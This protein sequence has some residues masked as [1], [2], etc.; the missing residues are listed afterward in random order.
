MALTWCIFWRFVDD[1]EW[2]NKTVR[3]YN[4]VFYVYGSVHR[5]S[6]LTLILLTWSIG[7]ARNN[8]SKWQMGFNS[9]FTGLI[10]VQRD[11]TQNSTFIILQ[12]HSTCFG[13]QP[14]PSS[15]VHK[16]VTTSSGTVQ[17]LPSNVAKLGHV[18]GRQLHK[19]I[20]PVPEA[21]VTVL[22]TPDDWCGW[23]PKHVE[24]TCRIINRLLCVASRWTII[25][26][27]H[28]GSPDSW[29]KKVVLKVQTV[30]YNSHCAKTEWARRPNNNSAGTATNLPG[31]MIRKLRS[32]LITQLETKIN[33]HNCHDMTIDAFIIEG[34]DDV[35]AGDPQTI[36]SSTKL[37]LLLFL[38]YKYCKKKV[39]AFYTLF[40]FDEVY[41]S[42][43]SNLKEVV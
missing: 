7:W 31:F 15:G 40:A 36:A 41:L 38:T 13:Y 35:V 14:H 19:K 9:A 25:N 26:I 1:K 32:N 16:S 23:H 43:V 11:A 5:W 20:R 30:A 34:D 22:C 3:I 39:F 18:G 24:W 2:Q 12:V 21:V 33:Y 8:A 27:Y 4:K 42:T 28:K 10:I 29:P 17:L 37:P 6:I